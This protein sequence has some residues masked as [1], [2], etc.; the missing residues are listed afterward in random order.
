MNSHT[1]LP[2][3][4]DRVQLGIAG[5]RF[6]GQLEASAP[7][8]LAWLLNHLPLEGALRQARWSGEAGWYPLRT[9]VR[10]D[11][12][13]A[14][15]HP[16][17][18]QILLYAGTENEPELLVPYGPCVFAYQGGPLSGNHIITLD[19]PDRLRAV[20]EALQLKG[21]QSFCLKLATN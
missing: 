5:Y 18:G 6:G 20:G 4:T 16:R 8:S 11:R 2:R 3:G 13:N 14:T 9:E 17:P 19:E 1:R 21:A 10:L 15:S 12:E 7:V